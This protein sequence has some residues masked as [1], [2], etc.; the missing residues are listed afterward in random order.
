MNTEIFS[1]KNKTALI[2]G[3]GTGI[4]FGIACA[5]IEAGARVVITGRN[6]DSL[7]EAKEKLGDNCY[8][9]V[10][11]VTQKSAVPQ[12]IEEIEATIAPIDILV[13]NA[14][15]HL[16]RWAMDTSDEEFENIIQTNLLS[17]F[18]LSKACAKKMAGRKNGVIL[19]IGSMAGIFGID[20]VSAYGTSKAALTGLMQNLVTE[21]SVHNIR[22]NTIAPGWIESPMFLNAINSDPDRKQKITNRIA[23]DHFGKVSDIGYT[24][25]FLSSPAASY[26]TGVVLPVDGGA[27]VNF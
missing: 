21:F 17:V 5:M 3:G 8:F 14:G 19:F 6:K 9:K 23:M 11:D 12:F 22:V 13:N 18:S 25:V 4:G 1:L 26:I 20:R 7:V 15:I 27:S 10:F 16:K 24:A 2:T